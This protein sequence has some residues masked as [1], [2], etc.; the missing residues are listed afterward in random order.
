MNL[1]YSSEKA[2]S[3]PDFPILGIIFDTRGIPPFV[4]VSKVWTQTVQL[5]ASVF[6]IHV[7]NVDTYEIDCNKPEY[8]AFIATIDLLILLSPYYS[9]AGKLLTAS[10]IHSSSYMVRRIFSSVSH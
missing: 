9:I 1:D 10:L 4:S 8:R 5:L 2:I 6:R 3:K 7:Y